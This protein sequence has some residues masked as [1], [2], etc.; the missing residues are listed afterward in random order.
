MRCAIRVCSSNAA[1]AAGV[2]ANAAAA[3]ICVDGS[4][5]VNAS[6]ARVAGLVAHEAVGAKCAHAIA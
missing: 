4:G 2:G 6:S 1:S 5:A 3:C